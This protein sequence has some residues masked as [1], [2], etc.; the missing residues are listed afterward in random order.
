MKALFPML[1]LL[2]A[3]GLLLAGTTRAADSEAL[4]PG[5]AAPEFS[6]LDQTG[7]TRTLSAYRPRWVVLYFY[8][9]DDTPGCT[10]EACAFRDAYLTLERRGVEVLGISVDNRDSHAE[11]ARKYHLPFPLLADTD[12]AVARRYGAL[13]SIG[14]ARFARRHTFIID[15]T[16]RIAKVYRSVDLDVHSREVQA[17]LETLQRGG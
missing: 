12:G 14:I 13:W 3:T 7:T 1:P 15:P 9:R 11:F 16:G 17:D 5:A 4:A 10:A 2:A 6:L 8:P